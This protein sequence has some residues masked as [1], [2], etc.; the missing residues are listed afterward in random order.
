MDSIFV[1]PLTAEARDGFWLPSELDGAVG[2][3]GSYGGRHLEGATHVVQSYYRNTFHKPLHDRRGDTI[4]RAVALRVLLQGTHIIEQRGG[5]CG[6]GRARSHRGTRLSLS[7]F[8]QGPA[9]FLRDDSKGAA[10]KTFW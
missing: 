9:F 7:H 8:L 3:V 6:G 1:L 10:V 5:L 2:P 4:E